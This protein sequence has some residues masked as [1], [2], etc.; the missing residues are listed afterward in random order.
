MSKEIALVLGRHEKPRGNLAERYDPSIPVTRFREVSH[1]LFLRYPGKKIAF[2]IEGADTTTDISEKIR[3]RVANG[4]SPSM[5][6]ISVIASSIVPKS[7]VRRLEYM[8][9]RGKGK[10]EIPIL[11]EELDAL[12]QEYR[13]RLVLI[14]EAC[15]EDECRQNSSQ[16]QEALRN[17][18]LAR[19]CVIDGNVFQAL[20]AFRASVLTLSEMSEARERRIMQQTR[21]ALQRNEVAGACLRFGTAHSYMGAQLRSEGYDVRLVFEH[22]G[23]RKL[24]WFRPYNVASRQVQRYGPESLNEYEWMLLTVGSV[25]WNTVEMRENPYVALKEMFPNIGSIRLNVPQ[26]VQDLKSLGDPMWLDLDE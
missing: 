25:L 16:F 17:K 20:E 6:L 11:F 12:Y 26:V 14:M 21:E 7:E 5:A 2:V 13:H 15:S 23:G 22:E 3:K 4:T 24:F 18:N 10:G 9:L 8:L 1:E 19:Q